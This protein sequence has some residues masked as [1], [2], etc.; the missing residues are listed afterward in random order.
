MKIL[1]VEDDEDKREQLRS[2]LSNG[3]KN[4]I[5]E[6]KSYQSGLKKIIAEVFELIVLDMTMPT[7]DVTPTEGG[8]RPQP[9]GG[10]ELLQQMSRRNIYTKTIVVTQFDQFGQ[11]DETTTLNELDKLL[12]ETFPDNYLGIVPYSVTYSGWKDNFNRKLISK[13]LTI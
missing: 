1:L 11:G 3:E 12:L 5:I 8:G 4:S 10:K 9:F 13:N 7:F 2:F 6:A